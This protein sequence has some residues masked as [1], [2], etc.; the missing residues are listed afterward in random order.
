[1]K[2]NDDVPHLLPLCII[3]WPRPPCKV[4]EVNYFYAYFVGE[5]LRLG[6]LNLSSDFM[7]L[8]GWNC[9]RPF[10]TLHLATHFLTCQSSPSFKFQYEIPH[11]I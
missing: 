1:M 6:E 5:E 3:S 4:K 9:T 11:E 2:I 8:E 7:Q 10:K